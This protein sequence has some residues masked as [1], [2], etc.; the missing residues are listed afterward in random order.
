MRIMLRRP[1]ALAESLSPAIE[2]TSTNT[3]SRFYTERT[4]AD[5]DATNSSPPADY[6][7]IFG[8]NRCCLPARCPCQFTGYA[9]RASRGRG[10]HCHYSLI[11]SAG[12]PESKSRN[13][14]VDQPHRE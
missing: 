14:P 13:E 11:W 3:V 2:T 6:K 10:G 1:F 5:L 12:V 4:D 8:G 9:D 7:Q